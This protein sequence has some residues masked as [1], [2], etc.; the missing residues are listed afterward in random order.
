MNRNAK[1]DK[2]IQSVKF[3]KRPAR[4]EH[5]L[6]DKEFREWCQGKTP[7]EILQALEHPKRKE[8]SKTDQVKV[9]STKE[10]KTITSKI[11]SAKVVGVTKT[12]EIIEA[13]RN[14]KLREKIKQMEKQ[15]L[16]D[17]LKPGCRCDHIKSAGNGL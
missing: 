13:D 12:K 10:S 6:N 2:I 16:I 7:E 8:D 3:K 5:H 4:S 1:G 11:A 9:L 14:A 15:K 17:G